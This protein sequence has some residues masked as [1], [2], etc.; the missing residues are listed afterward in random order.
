MAL[1]FPLPLIISGSLL[2]ENLSSHNI[3]EFSTHD[4]IDFNFIERLTWK[5]GIAAVRGSCIKSIDTATQEL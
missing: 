5:L 1:F 3:D 2:P 4:I